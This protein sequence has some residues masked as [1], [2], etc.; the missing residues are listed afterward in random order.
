[1][2]TT[3]PPGNSGG[4]NPP[5]PDPNAWSSAFIDALKLRQQAQETRD[6]IEAQAKFLKDSKTLKSEILSLSKQLY[7]ISRD[8]SDLDNEDLGTKET[9]L[10][11]DKQ[12]L[13]ATKAQASLT[14]D[15]NILRKFGTKEANDLVKTLNL[16]NEETKNNIILLNEQKKLSEQIRNNFGVK[17]YALLSEIFDKI[18]GKASILAKP[19]DQA[20]KSARESAKDSIL[21]NKK[22]EEQLKRKTRL[23]EIA[24]GQGAA[25]TKEEQK[26]L[27]L[28]GKK[29]GLLRSQASI[30]E[31][32]KELSKGM[33]IGSTLG[34]F[35][36][37]MKAFTSGFKGL[38]G[39]LTGLL[40]G[41]WIGALIGIGK[42]FIDA[43]FAADE[44]ITNIAKNFSVSKDQAAGIYESII[45]IKY[46]SDNILETTKNLTE[47]FIELRD[48]TEFI[49]QPTEDQLKL[50]VALTKNLGLS[51]EEALGF[52]QALIVSNVEASKGEETVYNQVAAF[53]KQ[54]KLLASG[55]QI[56]TEIGKTSKLIQINFKD[57]L[58][59]L[60]NTT[61]EAKKLGLTLDQ[62]SKIGKSL[63]NF[64]TSITAELEAEL[65]T[66][67][68]LNL[69]QA[70]YYALT[71]N[72][73]G[74]VG[75]IAKNGIT[76]ESF[77]SMNAIEQ[78]KIAA[79][80]G[81]QA[82]EMADTL[83]KADV[84]EKVSKGRTKDLRDQA[85]ALRDQGTATSTSLA[86]Q[87]EN[88]AALI[89]NA[90]YT[91]KSLEEAE[92]SVSAQDKFNVALEKAQE[93]FSDL[94]T[95]GTLD[96]L[97]DILLDIIEVLEDLGYGNKTKRLS[98]EKAAEEKELQ[99]LVTKS[100]SGILDPEEIKQMESLAN[101]RTKFDANFEQAIKDDIS[102][103]IGKQFGTGIGFID[104]ALGRVADW[105]TSPVEGSES[106]SADAGGWKGG[107][108]SM[109]QG[110]TRASDSSDQ[111]MKDVRDALVVQN[112]HLATIAAKD[113]NFYL[114]STKLT[115]G[116]STAILH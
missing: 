114:D 109:T 113:P 70:R 8:T 4:S 21:N 68:E 46:G 22:I 112:S 10:S 13:K 39:G 45:Q 9:L 56:M 100:K 57:N 23:D 6:A 47:A 59:N 73:A 74:L 19:F 49:V 53:A 58:P 97:S 81:M 85:Q 24:K 99:E 61:L 66:G 116:L 104:V 55:K 102:R 98:R 88:K 28:L 110:N 83:Y 33:D 93:L 36:I 107:A 1:M 35:E 62:V 7:E 54:N 42:F 76:I 96:A 111:L 69:E 5:N 52:Q 90:I 30:S 63:L 34:K 11:L 65:I 2:A 44:R 86:I 38:I 32:A 43:M 67:R 29:G 105:M 31:K 108:G 60:V 17:P 80:F 115:N 77:A 64:E 92:K 89:E 14:K 101:N 27:G 12:I 71:N 84:L 106:L 25:V 15:I 26:Q 94:V 79:A 87:L 51:K 16:Q 72:I 41:G 40:K 75:E 103:D 95:G 50:Q 78:E 3:P 91:G 18:G 48:I 37:G 20:A 82:D